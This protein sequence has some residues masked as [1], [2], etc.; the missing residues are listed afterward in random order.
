MSN[1]VSLTDRFD[2]GRASDALFDVEERPAF[3]LNRDG[4][5]T[6][7][8]S[9]KVLVRTDTDKAL[10][11]VSED[12]TLVK[13]QD[14]LDAVQDA[15]G[16]SYGKVEHRIHLHGD[17]QRMNAIF[18]FKDMAEDIKPGG[19]DNLIPVIRVGNSYNRMHRAVMEL[20]A[21]RMVCLNL[22]V[23]GGGFLSGFSSPHIGEIDVSGV[24]SKMGETMGKFPRLMNTYRRW[25]DTG[26]SDAGRAAVLDGL[27]P[28]G[29]SHTKT[30]GQRWDVTPPRTA[31][32]AY[33][34]VTHHATHRTRTVNTA[35]RLLDRGESVFRSV[36]G[37]A[38]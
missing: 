38:N 30:L 32:D 17:G 16:N 14:I 26:W 33:N 5:V 7:L 3:S 8:G 13:H 1:M 15:L 27:E 36:F 20:G 6:R 9:R 34:T 29:K 10:E 11:V 22:S 19:R 12:Y 31:W 37:H 28:M 18:K 4:K 35:Y 25:A 24:G 23:G 2:V 21:F